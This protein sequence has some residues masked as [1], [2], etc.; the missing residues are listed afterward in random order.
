MLVHHST[1]EINCLSLVFFIRS[2]FDPCGDVLFHLSRFCFSLPK[3]PQALDSAP[4][5][6][7]RVQTRTRFLDQ[8]R[9]SEPNASVSGCTLGCFGSSSCIICIDARCGT[10]T[11]DCVE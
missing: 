3:A 1:V 9:F 6:L 5:S 10:E 4:K 8:E 2:L 7:L 11:A